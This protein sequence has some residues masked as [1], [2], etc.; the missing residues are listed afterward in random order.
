MRGAQ[1]RFGRAM[2][3]RVE[4]KQEPLRFLGGT[5]LGLVQALPP[6]LETGQQIATAYPTTALEGVI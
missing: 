5:K 6:F 2:S 3:R 4:K 1:Q